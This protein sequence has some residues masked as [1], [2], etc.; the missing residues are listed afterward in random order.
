MRQQMYHGS[1]YCTVLGAASR[2]V[3]VTEHMKWQR[4]EDECEGI[5]IAGIATPLP[6]KILLIGA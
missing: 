1:K 6:H 5:M 3:V 2:N 4:R